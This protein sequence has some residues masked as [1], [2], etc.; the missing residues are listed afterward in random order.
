MEKITFCCSDAER[1]IRTKIGTA[2][3]RDPKNK[4]ETA[5]FK[6]IKIDLVG[7][8]QICSEMEEEQVANSH[9]DF[10]LMG[11]VQSGQNLAQLSNLTLNTP[12]NNVFE[13]RA[14]RIFRILLEI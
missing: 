14:V 2:K 11:K 8:R 4:P 10:F 1:Q 5:F 3:Q 6:F 7:R 12:C 13:I 9:F